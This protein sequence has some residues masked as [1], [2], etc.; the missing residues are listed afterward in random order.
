MT[1]SLRVYQALWAMDRLSTPEASLA[2]KFDRVR[3]AGF[4]GLAI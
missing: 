1:E 4:E 2:E 3:A